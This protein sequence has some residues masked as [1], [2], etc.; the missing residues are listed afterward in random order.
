MGEGYRTTFQ[1]WEEKTNKVE[2]SDE[3]IERAFWGTELE[4][5]IL[6]NIPKL[7]E[8]RGFQFENHKIRKDGKTYWN[9]DILIDNKPFIYGHLDGRIGLEIAE[10][11]FQSGFSYKAWEEYHVPRYFY[12]QGICALA[13]VPNAPSWRIYSLC[14]GEV[15][16]RTLHREE[17]QDDIDRF[18]SKAEEFWRKNV[19]EGIKPEP[20]SEDDL[21]RAYEKDNLKTMI[22]KPHIDDKLRQA[23]QLKNQADL[24]MARSKRLKAKLELGEADEITDESGNVLYTFKYV[25]PKTTLDSKKVKELYPEVYE[26]CTKV[27]EPSRR[28]VNK[29]KSE[30]EFEL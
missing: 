30:P 6:R 3:F 5:T 15:V 26:E 20:E 2:K 29:Q 24:I 7:M 17:V 13:V 28:L 12:W 9:K 1:L 4:E 10:I 11:K 22:M 14:N 19:L 8:Q 23:E 25:K 27:G 16:W 21:I 18:L